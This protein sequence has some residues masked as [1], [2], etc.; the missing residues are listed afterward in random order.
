MHFQTD[1]AFA[2]SEFLHRAHEGGRL[3]LRQN[4]I[5]HVERH[6]FTDRVQ[7]LHPTFAVRSHQLL[8]QRIGRYLGRVKNAAHAALVFPA[9]DDLTNLNGDR[10]AG[11]LKLPVFELPHRRLLSIRF[12]VVAP[13]DERW[14]GLKPF[15]GSFDRGLDL[16]GV[17][18]VGDL[19]QSRTDIPRTGCLDPAFAVQDL[20]VNS[21]QLPR[22]DTEPPPVAPIHLRSIGDRA[23]N[24]RR[25]R[26]QQNG[27][28]KRRRVEHK[29][30][31]A[32]IHT[33]GDEWSGCRTAGCCQTEIA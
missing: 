8:L 5:G 31:R 10:L 25:Q 17:A 20:L 30:P 26:Q 1:R 22:P 15:A 3:D 14:C 24:G 27:D 29:R 7:I 9:N 18:V 28:G 4:L 6:D 13:F 11:N 23:A 19:H 2:G 16:E 33:G 21:D 12:A 32:R